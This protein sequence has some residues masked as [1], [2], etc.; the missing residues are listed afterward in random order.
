MAKILFVMAWTVCMFFSVTCSAGLHDYPNIGILNF[1]NK[2]V[3]SNDINLEE[4]NMLVDFVENFLWETDRFN[5]I[6]RDELKAILDEQSLHMT[7]LIDPSTTVKIGNL[8]GAEYLMIG[9]LTGLTTKKNEV[10][11]DNN[12]AGG[13]GNTQYVV[14]ANITARIIEVSTGRVV[15][16]GMG[17]GSSTSTHTEFSVGRTDRVHVRESGHVSRNRRH[18]THRTTIS[19]D[20]RQT[21][22]IGAVELSQTQVQNAMCKAAE[23][24]IFGKF[25]LVNKMDGKGR[26]RR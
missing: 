12:R 18:Y 17:K 16:A 21:I 5:V 2:A 26:K 7:G 13:I 1:K 3:M 14:T 11:Y 24:L 20:P 9:S 10:I 15:L 4:P 22:R 8:T 25:G 19:V 6:E 23:D